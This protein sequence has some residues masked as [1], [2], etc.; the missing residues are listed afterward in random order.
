MKTIITLLVSLTGLASLAQALNHDGIRRLIAEDITPNSIW[1]SADTNA[2][3]NIDIGLPETNQSAWT[4]SD[5]PTLTVD[6]LRWIEMQERTERDALGL[7]PR[8]DPDLYM[9]VNGSWS[10]PE[11]TPSNGATNFA[12]WPQISMTWNRFTNVVTG[13]NHRGCPFRNTTTEI[14]PGVLS[15]T[16]LYHPYHEGCTT[17]V[18]PTERW[19]ITTVGIRHTASIAGFPGFLSKDEIISCSTNREVLESK[20]VKT[21]QSIGGGGWERSLKDSVPETTN[22]FWSRLIAEQWGKLNPN[23]N[24]QVKTP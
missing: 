14:A 6:V 19:T 10:G 24:P 2:C 15:T 18:A 3:S 17:Y 13:D 9:H 4:I 7:P 22:A 8:K 21:D 12:E 16:L 11:Y 5:K 1:H 20:W 23:T